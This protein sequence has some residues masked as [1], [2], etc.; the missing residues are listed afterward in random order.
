MNDANRDYFEGI[1]EQLVGARKA[2][3]W[4]PPALPTWAEIDAKRA[5][6]RANAAQVAEWNAA[7]PATIHT[8]TCDGIVFCIDCPM[9]GTPDCEKYQE[10]LSEVGRGD[11][12]PTSRWDVQIAEAAWAVTPRCDY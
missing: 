6:F 11:D 9:R 10:E 3:P 2:E 5:R 7:T 1:T 8:E 12:Y 4:T